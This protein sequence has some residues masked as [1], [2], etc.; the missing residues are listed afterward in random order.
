[1]LDLRLARKRVANFVFSYCPICN[2]TILCFPYFIISVPICNCTCARGGLYFW[3]RCFGLQLL[4]LSSCF[5]FEWSQTHM[6]L[7]FLRHGCYFATWFLLL[8]Y[9]AIDQGFPFLCWLGI[10]CHFLLDRACVHRRGLQLHA[11]DGRRRQQQ[12][13]IRHVM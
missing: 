9:E 5:Q 12:Q 1:M 7:K 3:H 11:P 13:G 6:H 10:E 4:S 2:F 8:G